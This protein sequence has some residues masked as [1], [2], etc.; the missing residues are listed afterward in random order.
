VTNIFDYIHQESHHHQVTKMCRILG[1]SRAQ[2]YWIDDYNFS[3]IKTKLGCKSP[4][5]YRIFTTQKAT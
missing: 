4:I 5:E 3:R 1:V 2:Y